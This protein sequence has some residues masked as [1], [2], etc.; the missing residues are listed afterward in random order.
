MCQGRREVK[1]KLPA[2]I[3]VRH[4]QTVTGGVNMTLNQV[5]IKSLTQLNGPF[6]IN[7]GIKAPLPKI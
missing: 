4:F 1:R 3:C 5:A 2:A 6:Q 7:L